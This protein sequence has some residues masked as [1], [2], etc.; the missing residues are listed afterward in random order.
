MENINI[1]LPE[2]FLTVSIL[3]TLMI[4]VFYKNS[5]VLVTSIIYGIVIALLLII[6]NSFNDSFKL[7]TNSFVSN[8]FTNFFKVLILVGTFFVLIITQN[9]IKETKINYFEYS[10]LLLLSVLGMFI[11]ISAND[12]ILFYLGL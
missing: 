11:M 1:F 7:F 12:L 4:G 9:F 10:L 8:S 2:I 6:I 3:I 5:Y